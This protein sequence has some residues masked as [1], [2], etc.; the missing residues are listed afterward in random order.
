MTDDKRRK[1]EADAVL[2]QIKEYN[3][4]NPLPSQEGKWRLD[5]SLGRLA[6]EGIGVFVV[7]ILVGLGLWVLF[8]ALLFYLGWR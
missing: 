6:L 3:R 4:K 8:E 1:L 7:G 2:K 5:V